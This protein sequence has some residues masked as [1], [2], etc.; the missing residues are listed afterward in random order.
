MTPTFALMYIEVSRLLDGFGSRTEDSNALRPDDFVSIKLSE[1]KIP[2]LN[3]H[4]RSMCSGRLKQTFCVAGTT[5]Q[6]RSLWTSGLGVFPPNGQV[7]AMLRTVHEELGKQSIVARPPT[8]PLPRPEHIST[9]LSGI[10][11]RHFPGV[12]SIRRLFALLAGWDRAYFHQ[13]TWPPV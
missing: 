13:Q 10:T 2:F 4:S 8:H 7:R 6:R 12:L 11:C 5:G 3:L 1:Q 9:R